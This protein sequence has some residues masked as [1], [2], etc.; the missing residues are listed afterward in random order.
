MAGT[1]VQIPAGTPNPSIPRRRIFHKENATLP[2]AAVLDRRREIALSVLRLPQPWPQLPAQ[3]APLAPGVC[4]HTMRVRALT[5][6][7]PQ[8][9][10]RPVA[11]RFLEQARPDLLPGD[12]IGGILLMTC[13]AV[14]QLSTL[15]VRQRQRVAF[16]AFPHR[17]QQFRFLG[18]GETFY[19]IS[20]V[21]HCL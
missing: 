16:Q 6:R 21:G 20:Q 14:I 1:R 11:S 8:A 7:P 5:L 9:A 3:N 13:D 17:I 18:S 4:C 12:D 19:L 2:H 10:R 15:L